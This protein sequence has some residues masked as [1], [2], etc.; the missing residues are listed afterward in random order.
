[1]KKKCLMTILMGGCVVFGAFAQESSEKGKSD[2]SVNLNPVVVTGTGTHQR[3]KNTPAPVEVITSN[4]L[5]KAGITDFQQAM[6]MMV[7]SL[8]FS[9]NSMGS[10]LMMNGLSNRYVLILINGKKLIGDTSDN[11][12]L[13]RI[14][15]NRV[16]R[17]EILNGAASSLYGSDA[18]AGVINIITD[19]P[20]DIIRASSNTR[21]EKYGQF[22]QSVN[23]DINKGKFGSYTSYKHEQSDGWQL[24]P[25]E[26]TNSETLET[27]P[28]LD[29]AVNGFHSN[30]FNQKFTFA[31]SDK[32]SFYAN[33]GYYWKLTDRPGTQDGIE[34]GTTYDLHYESYNFG[35]GGRYKLNNR[36]S[37]S[38]DLTSDNYNQNYKYIRES[39]DFKIGDYN[40]TKKQKL[41]DGDLKGIFRFTDNSTTVFGL[42]YRSEGLDRPSAGVDKSVYTA[43]AYGQHEVKLWD[44]FTGIAGLRYDYYETA[45]GNLSPKV[46]LMYS[47]S[48]LNVRGTYS[49]GFRVPSL[50][51]MYY[52]LFKTSTL[53]A[54]NTGLKP[55]SSNYFSLNMEY[56]T[57]N[58]NFSVTGYLNYI[59]DMINAKNEKFADMDPAVAGAI[60]EKA[61][62]DLGMT[63]S[64]VK[65]LTTYKTNRNLDEG[66]VRGVNVSTSANLGAGFSVSGNYAY[67]SA[68]GKD[69]EGT[70]T[71]INRAI[72]HSGTIAGN[73]AYDFTN[74]RMNINLNGR[75]QSK[76]QHPGHAYG[77][78][79][80]YGTWN[81]NTKYTFDNFRHFALEPGLGIDNIFDRTDGRPHGVNY[82]LLSPGRT[83]YVS[84][85]MRLK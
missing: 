36:S 76:R 48:N 6:T 58:F 60:K 62:E 66:I 40:K 4:D 16:R 43:A 17:I 69:A 41:Y 49:R 46:A 54:P 85:A 50:Y 28:T 47:V 37:I 9:T 52:Y 20:K 15:M 18:M 14:D 35:L 72:R 2:L 25:L 57:K 70:W 64:E 13:S 38:L 55:E 73:Y 63:D 1:M 56:T 24:S 33:G 19:E 53:T 51:D 82:G 27:T 30:V 32:L 10:Y 74:C 22:S 12:D 84:L 61:K 68:K 83:V 26:Y 5:K 23:V 65:K 67:A 71:P 29:R 44:H 21:Y 75:F 42:N 45:K 7:P 77:D 34:G 78:A 39:G 80:G 8:S 59:D 3:L 11:I 31:P 81:L 79:P